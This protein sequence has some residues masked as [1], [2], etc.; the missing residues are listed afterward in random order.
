[1]NNCKDSITELYH[2]LEAEAIKLNTRY[3]WNITANSMV[4][5]FGEDEDYKIAL[6]H[7]TKRLTHWLLNEEHVAGRFWKTDSLL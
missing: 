2:E 3:R 6:E 4:V 7:Y 5:A 1:M